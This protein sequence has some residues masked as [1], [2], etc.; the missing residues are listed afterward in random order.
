[1]RA[2]T[3]SVARGI[4]IAVCFALGTVSAAAD[5]LSDRRAIDKQ[6]Q[7][8]YHGERFMELEA[9]AERYRTG[10]RTGSGIWK[11]TVLY[12]TLEFLHGVDM[13]ADYPGGLIWARLDRWIAATPTAPTPR[14]IKAFALRSLALRTDQFQSDKRQAHAGWQPDLA[15]LDAAQKELE[16]AASFAKRDP[17]YF[18]VQIEIMRA[19]RAELEDILTVHNEATT[20][21]PLYYQTH[22]ATFRHVI[23]AS[24]IRGDVI[25]AFANT[26][27]EST[28]SSEGESVYARLLWSA[29]EYNFGLGVFQ[30][31]PVHTDRMM[32]GMRQIIKKYPSPWNAEHFALFSCLL[33]DKELLRAMFAISPKTPTEAIWQNPIVHDA[34]RKFVETR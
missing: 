23:P 26:V 9:L 16:A 1:M 5:E 25:T 10:E 21:H 27:Y 29:Y 13:V 24:S 15:Y 14:I 34:C 2:F 32:S 8:L 20:R 22:F 4:L 12:A 17:H 30:D 18:A 33:G 11:L 31:L 19:Q 7:P 6:V 28:K 3:F